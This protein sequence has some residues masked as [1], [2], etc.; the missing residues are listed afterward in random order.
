MNE[1]LIVAVCILFVSLSIFLVV[2]S[3]VIWKESNR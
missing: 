2:A 3:I 1:F